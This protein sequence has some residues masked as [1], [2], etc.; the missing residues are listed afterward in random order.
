MEKANRVLWRVKSQEE[1]DLAALAIDPD[2]AA[3]HR[4][5]AMEFQSFADQDCP[6]DAPVNPD[7]S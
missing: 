5:R 3:F 1:S 2:K 7:F 6:P 4:Q